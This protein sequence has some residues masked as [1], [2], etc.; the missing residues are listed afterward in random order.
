MLRLEPRRE[1]SRAMFYL[2]PFLAVVLT[3]LAGI[4]L[5]EVLRKPPL[6]AMRLIFIQP[7]TSTR[8]LAELLVKGTPLILIAIGLAVGFRGGIWNIGAEGQFAIGAVTGGSVALAVYPATGWW[9][10]PLMSFAGI[11]GGAAWAAIPARWCMGRSAIRT[12]STSPKAA[13]SKPR[14]RP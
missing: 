2:T 8:G 5:F 6:E 13:C 7:L 14:F 3:L 4:V 11:V 1:P 12:A 10:L 9:L